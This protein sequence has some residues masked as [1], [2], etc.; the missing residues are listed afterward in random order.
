MKLKT[1]RI[2]LPALTMAAWFTGHSGAQELNDSLYKYLQIAASANPAVNQKFYEYR[3]AL[4]K[5]PQAGSIPDPELSAG[6]FMKPMELLSGNQAADFRLMQMFPWFGVLKSA[7]DEMSLMALSAYESFRD[8]KLQVFY[9][10]QLT[11]Y[12]LYKIRKNISITEK[13]VEIL[14]T[15]EK[16]A[17]VS[18]RSAPASASGSLPLSPSSMGLLSGDAAMESASGMQTMGNN[19]VSQSRVNPMQPSG[20]MQQSSM[21][22]DPG[23]PRL[24][25]LYQL[26][27]ESAELQNLIEGLKDQDR[28]L[29]ARFNSYLNRHP[30]SPVFTPE[31]LSPDTLD[32]GLFSVSDNILER[33]PMLAMID[34]EARSVDARK[35]MIKG[36]GFPMLGLGLDYSIIGKS[37][38]SV[39]DMNGKDMVMPMISV[40]LPIYRKKYN[41]MSAEAD[42]LKSA[43]LNKYAS[44]A[45]NLQTEYYSAL[46]QF[47]DAK[48][49]VKLYNYQSQLASLSLDITIRSFSASAASL[50][51]LLRIRQQTYDNEIRES[52]AQADLNSAVALLKRLMAFPELKEEQ[53]Q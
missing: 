5:I 17:L 34:Y 25:D 48:R 28:T 6:I 46:Q 1:Y 35:K 30:E 52:E 21:G 19:Q 51:D 47:Q 32:I 26:R 10:V 33:N 44:T 50:T 39:S 43:S 2:L 49:R 38:M 42:F 18:Y 40:T 22:S 12:A 36:M 23:Q 45:S 37:G 41:A 13:N 14:K 7:K 27:I 16:L 4:Q 29:I 24:T 20:N 11:W 53:K 15:I 8:T 9:D 3:A 31:S